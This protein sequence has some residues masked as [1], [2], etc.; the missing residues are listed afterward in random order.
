[1]TASVTKVN[2]V[3]R[4]ISA[5]L[6]LLLLAGMIIPVLGSVG[7]DAYVNDD[8]VNV[9]TGPGTGYSSVYFNGSDAIQLNKGQYVRVIAVQRGSDG[10][11]WYQI[12]FV[13]KG[14]TKVGYMRS[15]FVT[16]IGDDRAYCKYLTSRAFPRATSPISG[17]CTPPAG[18]SGPLYPTRQGWTGPSPWKTSPPWAGR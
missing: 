6:V 7:T 11:D 2:T 18:A 4:L 16:Y 12:V 8:E 13:Y 15:D 10:Y 3:K 9:R 5:L 17:P 14:Y 1:M